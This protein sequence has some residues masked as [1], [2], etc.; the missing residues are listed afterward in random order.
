MILIITAVVSI[1]LSI[2]REKEKGTME[3]LYVSPVSSVE[4]LIGKTLPYT[5]I[6]LLI[7]ALVLAAGYILFRHYS[8]REIIFCFY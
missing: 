8:K 6:A 5:L 4:L 3:Q 1:A 7:S 2:V